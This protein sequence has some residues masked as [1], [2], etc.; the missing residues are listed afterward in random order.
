[1]MTEMYASLI[2]D[3]LNVFIKNKEAEPA[4]KLALVG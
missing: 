4:K 1:M 3:L 2:N